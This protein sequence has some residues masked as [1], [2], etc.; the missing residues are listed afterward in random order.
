M[1]RAGVEPF[2]M[3]DSLQETE[4]RPIMALAGGRRQ[5]LPRAGIWERRGRAGVRRTPRRGI[6]EAQGWA[7]ERDRRQ[8]SRGGVRR[9]PHHHVRVSTGSLTAGTESAPGREGVP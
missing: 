7:A 4:P 1:V 6:W 5:P 2:G 3:P 9:L 8:P